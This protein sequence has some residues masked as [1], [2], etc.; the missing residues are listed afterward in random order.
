MDGAALLQLTSTFALNLG[1]SCLA[2]SWLAARWLNSAQAGTLPVLRIMDVVAALMVLVA[3]A[4]ALWAATAVM[5]GLP[6]AEAWPMLSTML[7][8][9]DYG[10]A[11]AASLLA[12]LVFLVLRGSGWQGRAA[13]TLLLLALLAFAFARAS[14]SHAGE[15]GWASM[16]FVAEVLHLCAIA[17]WTGLVLVS[18]WWVLYPGT[19][20][21]HAASR[22]HYLDAMSDTALGAVLLIG[23]TGVYG[24][25]HRLGAVAPLW[26]TAYGM[27]LLCKILLVA[28][29]I[30]LGG[31][32]K[33]LGLPAAYRSAAGVA[34]VR[35]VLQLESLLLLGALAA[36]AYLTSQAPPAFS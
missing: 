1:F 17:V 11:G 10:R 36:A 34:T 14:M 13:N 2:G 31:Y 28:L 4:S 27:T 20:L 16:V 23:A 9:T 19:A 24:A 35:R 22:R 29:A 32:N 25:A 6:L 8:T 18:A 15:A 26:E 33:L 12:I 21:Q 30:G 5:A 3:G 7:A